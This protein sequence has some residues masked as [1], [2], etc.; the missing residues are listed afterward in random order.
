M[1]AIAVEVGERTDGRWSL[2]LALLQPALLPVFTALC[3][4]I[5]V[6]TVAGVPIDQLGAAVLARLQ[7]W[8]SLLERDAPGLG[9]DVLRG[10]IGELSVLESYLFPVTPLLE[11][12]QAW[13]GPMGAPQDFVLPSGSLIEVKAAERDAPTVRINGAAQLDGGSARL[14]LAVVRLQAT[15]AGIRGSTT[16]PRMVARI[17]DR[18]T[19]DADAL[20]DFDLSL[21]ALGW[22]VHPTHD[23]FAVR[24]LQID[25]YDV[26]EGFPRLTSAMVPQ[27]VEDVGYTVI[28]PP[29]PTETWSVAA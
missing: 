13:R 20:R 12:V 15:A 9:E 11:A 28:L 24:V 3:E 17:R 6:F 16:A 1:R 29:T 8:R 26:T 18:L 10:L 22:H 5:I 21:S 2:R 25:V 27:G 4:D 19:D 14:R 23:E 7:R